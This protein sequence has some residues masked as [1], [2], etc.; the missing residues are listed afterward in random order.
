MTPTL[1]GRWQTRL[2]LLG[3]LGTAITSGYALLAALLFGPAG[4]FLP[5]VVLFCAA[6]FGLGWDVLYI[7]L[8]RLRWE[9]DWPPIFD[10][11]TGLAEGFLL[12]LVALALGV[13]ALFFLFH[14]AS[15]WLAVFLAVHGPLRVLFPRW[16]Y[17]GGQWL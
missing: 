13:P 11:G 14:Y 10:L 5:F 6:T 15:V 1:L 8:Q 7:L 4:F 9:R 3:T 17:R 2:L 12:L 16:R